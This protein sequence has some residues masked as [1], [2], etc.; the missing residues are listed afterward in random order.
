MH[1]QISLE[2]PCGVYDVSLICSCSSPILLMR[3]LHS[4]RSS[5]LPEAL[6]QTIPDYKS[7]W[8]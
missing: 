7:A 6:R 4:Q 1:D 3:K 5:D 8:L 2:I